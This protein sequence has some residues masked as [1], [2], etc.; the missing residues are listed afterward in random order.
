MV[1]FATRF[2]KQLE[3]NDK[4]PKQITSRYLSKQ[5]SVLFNKDLPSEFI[6]FCRT[7]FI[8]F[9]QRAFVTSASPEAEPFLYDSPNYE[10]STFFAC[11]QVSEKPRASQICFW[12]TWQHDAQSAPGGPE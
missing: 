10:Y 3:Q 2:L 6:P 1:F 12:L 5:S 4:T 7:P 11:H 9:S 8:A